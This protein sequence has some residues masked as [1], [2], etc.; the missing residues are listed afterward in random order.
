MRKYCLA[1]VFE[2]FYNDI[3]VKEDHRGS[4]DL[5]VS[6]IPSGSWQHMMWEGIN[7]DFSVITSTLTPLYYQWI[8]PELSVKLRIRV[9]LLITWCDSSPEWVR[10]VKSKT[11]KQE[12]RA[13]RCQLET[14]FLIEMMLHLLYYIIG[15]FCISARSCKQ[16][17][18][19]A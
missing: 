17:I 15:V 4:S 1:L 2:K 14:S 7:L 10:E 9:M 16:V 6:H 11:K 19:K 8:W 12:K 18:R 13:K 3:L 5:H